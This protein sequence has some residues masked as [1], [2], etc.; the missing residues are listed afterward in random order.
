LTAEIPPKGPAETTAHPTSFQLELWIPDPDSKRVFERF[1]EELRSLP[2][3]SGIRF[4]LA[5][6][7]RVD[8]LDGPPRYRAAGRVVEWE[9]GHRA[10]VS[11]TAPGGASDGPP[12]GIAFS[13]GPAQGGTVLSVVCRDWGS[14]TSWA[15]PEELTGW[16]ASEIVGPIARS[17][18]PNST[19]DWCL[20]RAARRPTGPGARR[21]YAE[22][23]HHR[24]NFAI[25]LERL[26]LTKSD[27]LLEVGCGGGAFLHDA[28]RSG[29][30]AFAIDHSPDMVATAREQNDDAVT[31]GRLDVREADAEQLPFADGICTCA[32]STG[33]LH[34]IPHPERAF[35]EI[36]RVLKP[37]GRFFL[38]V[39]SKEIRGTPAAPEPFAS[40]N[41]FF[42]D[43][44]L[45]DLA[46]QVGFVRVRVDR[47]DELPY[48]RA[49]GLPDDV[50]E[51]FAAYPRA[52]QV[53][54][55]HKPGGARASRPSRAP[56]N[57]RRRSAKSR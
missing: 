33:V 19:I 2:R 55:A 6:D 21:H 48:A 1:R 50:I 13:C 3:R 32:I 27:R 47:P 7:G 17:L 51:F 44:E 56:A 52:G 40:R 53:L 12:I 25:L 36:Y 26:R 41:R 28:L 14:H 46:T 54:E 9:A 37:G 20:D 57:R 43:Q 39:G 11:W 22:P 31:A 15:D 8:A 30:R 24:P 49:A 18:L 23:I 4:D 45:E 38:F 42:E 16:I 35:S 10:L 34:F 29:C 5:P